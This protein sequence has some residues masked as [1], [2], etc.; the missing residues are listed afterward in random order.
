M[1]P[2]PPSVELSYPYPLFLLKDPL[3]QN[4]FIPNPR[5]IL[6]VIPPFVVPITRI[7]L[8]LRSPWPEFSLSLFVTRL[9][10]LLLPCESRLFLQLELFFH[11]RFFTLFHPSLFLYLYLNQTHLPH[12][13]N[14]L[15]PSRFTRYILWFTTLTRQH[16][17]L[18][19]FATMFS[20]FSLF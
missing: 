4:F 19:D 6:L 14:P 13:I 18:F 15:I 5:T 7:L 1:P 12:S 20:S 17:R 2:C 16:F 9:I 10:Q 11:L 3:D 8:T